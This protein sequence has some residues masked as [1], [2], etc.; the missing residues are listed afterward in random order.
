MVG[1]VHVHSARWLT[2]SN[3]E[4]TEGACLEQVCHELAA[5]QLVREP[6]RG[7][8]LLDLAITYLEKAASTVVPGVSDHKIMAT[9]IAVSMPTVSSTDRVVWNYRDADW[10]LLE[11]EVLEAVRENKLGLQCSTSDEAAADLTRT[12]LDIQGHAITQ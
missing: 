11:D 3:G 6:S 5:R 7:N 2:H 8:Y 9:E 10:T 12:L 4:S 1:D